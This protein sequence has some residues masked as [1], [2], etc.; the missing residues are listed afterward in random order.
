MYS[1]ILFDFDGTVYDT[2]EGITKCV[3]YALR[4]HGRD[5]ELDVAHLFVEHR[6]GGES[7]A[8]AVWEL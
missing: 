4:K 7:Y 8:P 5:A 3:Q 6:T 1:V 2:V